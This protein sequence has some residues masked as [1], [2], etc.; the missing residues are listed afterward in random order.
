MDCID[1]FR[2]SEADVAKVCTIY[3]NIMLFC[4]YRSQLQPLRFKSVAMLFV[5]I[6][7]E[8]LFMLDA[9]G[10]KMSVIWK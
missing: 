9:V 6:S 2:I 4:F 10:E 3:L 5:E 7:N 8:I 1:E